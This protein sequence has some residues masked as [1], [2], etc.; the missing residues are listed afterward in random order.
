MADVLAVRHHP[1]CKLAVQ[2]C[3]VALEDVAGEQAGAV[4]PGAIRERGE[5]GDSPDAGAVG[6]PRPPGGN[7]PAGPPLGQVPQPR[8]G[9]AG[10]VEH[11]GVV[12]R[13]QP[14]QVPGVAR[15]LGVPALSLGQRGNRAAR[16][17]Q[18]RDGLLGRCRR[19]IASPLLLAAVQEGIGAARGQVAHEGPQDHRVDLDRPVVGPALQR[20]LQ[21]QAELPGKP[22]EVRLLAVVR[23]VALLREAGEVR[24]AVVAPP[25]AVPGAQALAIGWLRPQPAPVDDAPALVRAI[26]GRRDAGQPGGDA[27]AAGALPRAGMPVA[28]PRC[29]APKRH[30]LTWHDAGG[31]CPY[32]GWAASG[33]A[34][35]VSRSGRPLAAHRS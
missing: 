13:S 1:A 30:P 12:T 11:R 4:G 31:V 28:S 10:E 25:A 32:H 35:H 22:G 6:H 27:G 29:M 23:R 15:V 7:P 3:Q 33:P 24:V 21:L 34:I 18:Q 20:V 8:L 5:P 19:G 26:L 16:V 14:P 17:G 9:D 2:V